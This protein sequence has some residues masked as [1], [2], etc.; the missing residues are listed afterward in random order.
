MNT[1]FLTKQLL[2][3]LTGASVDKCQLHKTAGY[4]N[5][6][7]N[8]ETDI[9]YVRV[10]KGKVNKK[11]I[12]CSLLDPLPFENVMSMEALKGKIQNIIISSTKEKKE[13]KVK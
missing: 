5:L 3:R 11:E 6:I 10:Q 9:L 13:A 2:N 12:F 4:Q 7:E 1:I 8:N